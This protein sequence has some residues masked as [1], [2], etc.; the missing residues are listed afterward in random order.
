M[1]Q[2]LHGVSLPTSRRGGSGGSSWT[3]YELAHAR[4]TIAAGE[5]HTVPLGRQYIL[6]GTL[7]VDGTLVLDGTLINL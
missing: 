5:V 2:F 7:T 4:D 3:E 1:S 6:Y